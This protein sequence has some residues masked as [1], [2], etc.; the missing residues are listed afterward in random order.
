V[1]VNPRVSS[2]ISGS[3]KIDGSNYHVRERC[4]VKSWMIVLFNG[5]TYIYIYICIC[6]YIYGG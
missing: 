4:V 3:K 1:A 2:E 5:G 6:I